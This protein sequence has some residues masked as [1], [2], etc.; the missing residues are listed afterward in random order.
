MKLIKLYHQLNSYVYNE[1]LQIEK[2]K[3]LFLCYR[4]IYK[5]FKIGKKKEIRI[6]FFVMNLPMWRYQHLYELLTK[7]SRF[8]V[9][10]ALSPSPKFS[11]EQRK[12]DLITL[13][14]FFSSK[15]IPF[16]D[17]NLNSEK[18]AIDIRK[19]FCP[20]ILFY[21]Q[22]YK[23]T[24]VEDHSYRTFIDKLLCY[25]PYAFWT[26]NGAWGYNG[27]FHNTAWKLYY[28]TNINKNEAQKYAKNR[29]KNVVVVGYPNADDFLYSK[30][31]NVWKTQNTAKKRIIWAP[32]FTISP[33]ISPLHQSNFL[34]MAKFMVD[35]SHKYRDDIQVAFKPHP[36]LLTELYKHP[37]WGKEK[38][39]SYYNLWKNGENTQLETGQYID[40]FMTSDA[41]IHDSS[42]F[43]IEYLYSK[44]PVL[45]ITKNYEDSISE[46]NTIGIKALEAHYIA[47]E[48]CEIERFIKN[49]VCGNRDTKKQI[50]N[51]YFKTYLLPPNGKTVA[52]NTYIDILKSLFIKE[53]E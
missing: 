39:D 31:L 18:S 16:I 40:L 37:D 26:S 23:K 15:N 36:R 38:T 12:Q 27:I 17:Y 10:I 42:S 45:Y 50:R 32:H 44:K 21:P 6:V 43:T 53:K 3:I 14:D 33:G 25:Y 30:H 24:L 5:A 19:D 49:I 35:L 1:I 34:W 9:V 22:P 29:G 13:R 11:Y 8:N 2:V 48:Y 20:D 46:K 28:S 41:M 4:N 52:E 51:E 47:K 7:D